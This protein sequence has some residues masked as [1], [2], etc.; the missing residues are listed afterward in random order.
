V[1]SSGVA[2]N[3][4]GSTTTFPSNPVSFGNALGSSWS[5]FFKFNT[6]GTYNYRCD[7]H[8]SMGMTGTITVIGTSELSEKEKLQ[9]QIT[10]FPNPAEFNFSILNDSGVN[11]TNLELYS[12]SGN[13]ILN[14]PYSDNVDLPDLENGIYYIKLSNDSTSITKMVIIE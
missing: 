13:N 12:T 4:N 5:Y 10:I 11:F 3:V 7:A 6:A 14:M 1:N 9:N 8:F 2:H